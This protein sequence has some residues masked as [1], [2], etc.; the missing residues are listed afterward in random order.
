M[1]TEGPSAGCL[2]QHYTARDF[3]KHCTNKV[4]YNET[5]E[6]ILAGY[7]FCIGSFNDFLRT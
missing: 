5:N 6:S 7:N 2:Y 3:A 4:K 1:N